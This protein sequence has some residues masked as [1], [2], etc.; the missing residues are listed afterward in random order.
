MRQALA[1]GGKHGGQ[2]TLV[3]SLQCA[4][5]NGRGGNNLRHCDTMEGAAP[6]WG[7]TYDLT[8]CAQIITALSLIS[9]S[10]FYRYSLTLASL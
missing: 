3:F 8:K 4:D 9:F 6:C 10:H 5:R 7:F 1:D 2:S